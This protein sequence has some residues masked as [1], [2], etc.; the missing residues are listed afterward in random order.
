MDS[1]SPKRRSA[2]MSRIRS[3][4]TKPELMVRG[5]I[6]AMGYRYRLHVKV[7]PGKPDIVFRSRKAVIFVH[8]CFW[9]FHSACRE[10]RVPNSNQAYW[11]DKLKRNVERDRRHQK[12]L[13]KLGWRV[14]VLWEC[15]VVDSSVFRAKLR[16]FLDVPSRVAQ[17]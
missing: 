7:L 11:Q 3:V 4:D 16:S 5:I 10:G 17:I 2:N 13:K 9:H 1:L 15:G 6:H 8:G 14:L 12:E